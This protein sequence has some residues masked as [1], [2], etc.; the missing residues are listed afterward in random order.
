MGVSGVSGGGAA[1]GPLPT[2]KS[3]SWIAQLATLMHGLIE[4]LQHY[5]P[6]E[7]KKL[8]EDVH[9]LLNNKDLSTNQR[10][11]LEEVDQNLQAAQLAY[12]AGGNPNDSI[13]DALA[14]IQ[15]MIQLRPP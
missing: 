7:M 1:Q 4:Q 10:E 9:N 5:N 13:N 11:K 8:L 12:Q 6:S 2:E 14:N 3:E 15:E